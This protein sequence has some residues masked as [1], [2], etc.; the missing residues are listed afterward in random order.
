M[1]CVFFVFKK[2]I[3]KLRVRRQVKGREKQ[4]PAI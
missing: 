4:L 1:N 2:Y 3:A